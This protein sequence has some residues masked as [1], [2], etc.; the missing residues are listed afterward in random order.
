HGSKR[1]YASPHKIDKLAQ[2]LVAAA[3]GTGPGAS[4]ATRLATSTGTAISSPKRPGLGGIG[5][6]GG[7]GGGVRSICCGREHSLLLTGSGLVYS[8]GDNSR[9]QLGHSQ[10]ENCAVPKL[11][12]TALSASAAANTALSYTRTS[13]GGGGGGGSG[14]SAG[15]VQLRHVQLIAC[16]PVV[17]AHNTT[18]ACALYR[19]RATHLV[20]GQR[21]VVARVGAD[22]YAWGDNRFGQLGDGTTTSS[23]LAVRVKMPRVLGEA[24]A[25]NCE[26]LCGGR[27]NVLLTRGEVWAWGWNKYGAVGTGSSGDG[28]GR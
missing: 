4:T 26:L 24:E 18:S 7:F 12:S 23:R 27:H 28:R 8:W 15:L 2:W 21:H 6:L 19:K 3:D 13:G 5:G 1:S 17:S 10:Y 16:E 9:G 11:V 22:F 14:G 25:A 20:A